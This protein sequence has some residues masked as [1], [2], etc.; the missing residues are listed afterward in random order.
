MF[1]ISMS[2]YVFSIY[3]NL[4]IGYELYVSVSCSINALKTL[5]YM[6]LYTHVHE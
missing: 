6:Y 5:F 3:M 4:S 1:L 2:I